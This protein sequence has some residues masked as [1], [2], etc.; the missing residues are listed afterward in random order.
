MLRRSLPTQL[1]MNSFLICGSDLFICVNYFNMAC[2]YHLRSI[3]SSV[4]S[5]I[6]HMQ[7][8]HLI[9]LNCHS[10]RSYFSALSFHNLPSSPPALPIPLILAPSPQVLPIMA[11][12]SLRG[13]PMH[14]RLFSSCQT[15]PPS[16]RAG[17]VGILLLEMCIMAIIHTWTNFPMRSPSL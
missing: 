9:G 13:C 7:C 8:N 4:T 3:I 17:A 10:N 2:I 5:R 15:S 1:K 6:C 16:R 12:K 11:A 14:N